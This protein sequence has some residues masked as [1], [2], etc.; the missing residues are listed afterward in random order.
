MN[1][2]FIKWYEKLGENLVR[3]VFENFDLIEREFYE[4][5]NKEEVIDSYLNIEYRRI[6]NYRKIKEL[7]D[8]NER[9]LF[10]MKDIKNYII[11]KLRSEGK[12]VN[13]LMN[14]DRK[15][16]GKLRDIVD[17]EKEYNEVDRRKFEEEKRNRGKGINI[18]LNN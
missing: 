5:R 10:M 13:F 4:E 18:S 11:N 7:K 12:L 1:K 8:E 15:V 16:L 14:K 6:E 17:I 2:L 9:L 3:K